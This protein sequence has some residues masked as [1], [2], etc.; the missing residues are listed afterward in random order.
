MNKHL[1]LVDV[2]QELTVKTYEEA[3]FC[4]VPYEFDFRRF[5]IANEHPHDLVKERGSMFFMFD[6][7][8][9][10]TIRTALQCFYGKHTLKPIW[11]VAG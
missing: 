7:P 9:Y 11:R 1:R 10:D 8:T 5:L 6:K 4:L 2:T 3:D